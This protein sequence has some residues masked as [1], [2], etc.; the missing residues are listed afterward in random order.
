MLNKIINNYYLYLNIIYHFIINSF[1][2]VRNSKKKNPFFHKTP[3]YINIHKGKDFL[4]ILNGPSILKY[5]K[6]LIQ[7]SKKQ[8]LISITCNKSGN[9][10]YSDYNIFINKNR[11]LSSNI[12]E[13]KSK[14]ILL[15][16]YFDKKIYYK[17][18]K[19]FSIEILPNEIMHISNKPRFYLRKG[20]IY[21]SKANGGIISI[22]SAVN[23]GAKNIYIAGMDGHIDGSNNHFYNETDMTSNNIKHDDLNNYLFLKLITSKKKELNIDKLKIITPTKL[24]EFYEK[25]FD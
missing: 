11:F 18:T 5:K 15:S 24:N 16:S 13:N 3:S 10:L 20:I 17:L 12:D 25:F 6:E 1:R 23:M 8:N 7:F 14:K 21:H 9:F 22:L 2:H 19:K 4:I